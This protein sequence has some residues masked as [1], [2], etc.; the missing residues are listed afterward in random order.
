VKHVRLNGVSKKAA[1]RNNK[2]VKCRVGKT[3]AGKLTVIQ[4]AVKK[5][6]VDRR[7]VLGCGKMTS[8]VSVVRTFKKTYE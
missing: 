1:G 7:V 6:H 2:Q 3:N 4:L 8:N 5:R